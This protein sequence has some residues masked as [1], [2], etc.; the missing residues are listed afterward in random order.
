MKPWQ[1]ILIAVLLTFLCSAVI[2]I[3]A[4][5]PSQEP[6]II[7]TREPVSVVFEV[8]GEVNHPGIYSSD[9]SSIR[10]SDA[11][12]LAGGFTE[13]A[14]PI[15]S[16]LAQRIHDGDKIIIPTAGPYEITL[17]PGFR[18]GIPEKVNLNTASLDELMTLPGI[19]EKKA[20]DIINYRENQR[21]FHNIADLL[22]IDGFGEKTIEQFYDLVIAE[23]K[24][25]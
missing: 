17:T 4:I 23:T 16:N 11:V 19:G 10:V 6:I 8:Y 7:Q 22:E 21:L 15:N 9:E 24:E 14:D 1:S 18:A 13:K 2:L 5:R 12:R 20:Q 25:E 3:L